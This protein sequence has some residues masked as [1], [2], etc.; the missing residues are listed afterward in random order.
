MVAQLSPEFTARLVDR[1]QELEKQLAQGFA[2][3]QNLPEAL[4][5]A[6]EAIEERDKLAIDNAA[7]AQA[8]AITTPKAEALDKFAT[9]SEGAMCITDAAKALQM[10]PKALFKWLHENRWIYRRT[11][12]SNWTGYQSICQLGLLEHKVTTVDRAD[13]LQR[14]V[15]QVLVTAKGLAK[16]GERLSTTIPLPLL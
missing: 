6:A 13:G 16:L 15:Q 14:V 10:Q 12:K 7:Q 5:L 3:P 8:L 9:F 1:W 11:G 4:R 2:I